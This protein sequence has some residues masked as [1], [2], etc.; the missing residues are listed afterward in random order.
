MTKFSL[1]ENL[2]V[3]KKNLKNYMEHF[4]DGFYQQFCSESFGIVNQKE[5]QMRTIIEEEK[6][7]SFE[8]LHKKHR[9]MSEF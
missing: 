7:E 3:F 9:S 5:I 4:I 1:Q 2:L 6:E 8:Y